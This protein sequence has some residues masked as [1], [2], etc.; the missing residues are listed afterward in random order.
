MGRV[1][2]TG[3]CVNVTSGAEETASAQDSKTRYLVIF[4]KVSLGIFRIILVSKEEQ[5]SIIES[6]DEGLSLSRFS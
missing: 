6:K 4:K 3:E 5:N 2:K 1:A